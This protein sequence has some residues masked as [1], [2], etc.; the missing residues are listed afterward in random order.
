MKTP[1]DWQ[2]G[3]QNAQFSLAPVIRSSLFIMM[4]LPFLVLSTSNLHVARV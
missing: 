1:D 4:T 3:K 2:H